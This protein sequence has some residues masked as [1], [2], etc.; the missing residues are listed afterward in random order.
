MAFAPDANNVGLGAQVMVVA[1]NGNAGHKTLPLVTS[2][3]VTV[4][5]GFSGPVYGVTVA[6]KM[7]AS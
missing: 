5:D 1:V 7:G 2:T 4:P 6:V 3:K